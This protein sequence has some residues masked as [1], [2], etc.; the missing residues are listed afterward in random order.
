MGV[1]G[2]GRVKAKVLILGIDGYIGWPLANHLKG[3]GYE[4]SGVDNGSRRLLVGIS[5]S[6]SL[7]PIE[8]FVKKAKIFKIKHQSVYSLDFLPSDLSAIVH[9]AEQPSAIWLNTLFLH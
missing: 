3:L 9:L 1:E 8:S 6:D 5:G 4:V 2:G 7:I